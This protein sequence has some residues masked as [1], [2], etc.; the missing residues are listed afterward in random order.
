MSDYINEYE[1][2]LVSLT[3]LSSNHVEEI[4][5]AIEN[6]I[7]REFADTPGIHFVQVN[8]KPI[9]PHEETVGELSDRFCQLARE[10]ANKEWQY[11]SRRIWANE[12]RQ[13]NRITPDEYKILETYYGNLWTYVGD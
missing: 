3:Q 1:V 6:F 2:Q 8:E 7:Y 13:Q 5:R 9:K 12:L 11:S 4:R 10:F